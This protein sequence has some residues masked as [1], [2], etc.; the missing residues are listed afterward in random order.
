MICVYVTPNAWNIQNRVTNIFLSSCSIYLGKLQ[1]SYIQHII[2]MRKKSP[3][4]LPKRTLELF[5]IGSL[6]IT[7]IVTHVVPFI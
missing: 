7:T 4:G 1:Y 2:R 6:Q 5:H 3:F